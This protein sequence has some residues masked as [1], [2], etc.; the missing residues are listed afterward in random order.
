MK[1]A[2]YNSKGFTLTEMMIVVAIIAL[3][4]AIALPSFMRARE[5]ARSAAFIGNLRAVRSAFEI[6]SIENHGYPPNSAA[7]VV[8]NGMS[9]YLGSFPW[10]KATPIGGKWNWDNNING[11]KAGVAVTS[12]TADITQMYDIDQLFDDG[13]L[14]TGQFRIRPSGYVFVIE[15]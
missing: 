14:T 10:T 3:L 12:I 11:Y 9:D 7:G 8:P 2:K 15:D 5:K 13:V 1:T 4:A 6:Y